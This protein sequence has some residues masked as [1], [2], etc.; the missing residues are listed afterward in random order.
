[1]R[2][3]QSFSYSRISQHFMEPESSLPYSQHPAT[4]LCP[5]LDESSPYQLVLPELP[6]PSPEVLSSMDLVSSVCIVTKLRAGRLRYRGWISCKDSDF[7]VFHNQPGSCPVGTESYFPFVKGHGR[8]V[9]HSSTF[10][11]VVYKPLSLPYF[12]R[13]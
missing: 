7:T 12:R 9:G 13:I 10:L 5:K 8:E 4:G 6:M 1:L 3:R 11:T 2:S